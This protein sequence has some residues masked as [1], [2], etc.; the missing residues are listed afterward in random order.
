MPHFTAGQF[1]SW[2]T[3]CGVTTVE[4]MLVDKFHITY[5]GTDDYWDGV[6]STVFRSLADRTARWRTATEEEIASFKARFRPGPQNW[7]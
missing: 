4:I 3:W 6:E 1:V 5:R 2:D 7:H